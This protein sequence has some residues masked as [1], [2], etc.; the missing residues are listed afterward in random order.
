MRDGIVVSRCRVASLLGRWVDCS[1]GRPGTYARSRHV[2]AIALY[3]DI[4]QSP[5]PVLTASPVLC[6]VDGVEWSDCSMVF[7]V[8]VSVVFL[9]VLLGRNLEGLG[10]LEV[11]SNG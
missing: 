4:L 9:L 6:R 8:K 11:W 5:K 3:A 2:A 7:L 1:Q 10:L